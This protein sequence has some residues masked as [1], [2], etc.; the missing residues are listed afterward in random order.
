MGIL[1]HVD[2]IM[3]LFFQYVRLI[4]DKGVE[5][6]RYNELKQMAETVFKY[7]EKTKPEQ[8]VQ[9]LSLSLQVCARSM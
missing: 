4:I 6:W 1:E 9:T 3:T 2:D 5:D 8:Y 7:L